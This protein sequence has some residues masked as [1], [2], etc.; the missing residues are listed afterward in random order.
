MIVLIIH[1]SIPPVVPFM[2]F[3]LLNKLRSSQYGFKKLEI[4]DIIFLRVNFRYINS[5]TYNKVKFSYPEGFLLT[6]VGYQQY[7][8]GILLLLFFLMADDVLQDYDN[9]GEL[10]Q[11]IKHNA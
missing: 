9:P 7:N 2:A 4:M 10:S 1:F 8:R 5:T 6:F 3:L 11:Y